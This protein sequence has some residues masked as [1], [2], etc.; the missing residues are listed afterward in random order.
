MMFVKLYLRTS[1]IYIISLVSLDQPGFHLRTKS[2]PCIEKEPIYDVYCI[3][4]G[5]YQRYL[6]ILFLECSVAQLVAPLPGGVL[7]GVVKVAGSNLLEAKYL[8]H[9]SDQL[10][11]SYIYIYEGCSNMNASSFIIFITYMLRQSVI[12]V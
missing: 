8:Q 11:H 7:G 2:M 1:D 3:G 4:H 6:N 9:L 12:T 5:Q 10:I